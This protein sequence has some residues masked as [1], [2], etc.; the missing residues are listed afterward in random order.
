[1][2]KI[3]NS[4]IRSCAPD[5]IMQ[6]MVY[7]DDLVSLYDFIYQSLPYVSLT[8]LLGSLFFNVYTVP[9]RVVNFLLDLQDALLYN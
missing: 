2:V 8:S 4:F 1:M 6:Q 5:S 9:K 3:K 7:L